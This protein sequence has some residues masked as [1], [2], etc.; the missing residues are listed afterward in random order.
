MTSLPLRH[1]EPAPDGWRTPESR[2]LP[3]KLLE[4]VRDGLAAYEWP[5]KAHS[6]LPNE[7]LNFRSSLTPNFHPKPPK[8][9]LP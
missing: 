7:H 9:I 5:D 2:Q 4:R 8:H 6:V 3:Y 1:A